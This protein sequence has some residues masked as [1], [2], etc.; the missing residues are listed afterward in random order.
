MSKLPTGIDLR[1]SGLYRVRVQGFPSKSFSRLPDAVEHRRTLTVAKQT[2]RMAQV[3]T[4]MIKLRELASEH[5][6]AEGAHLEQRTKNAYAAL[7]RANVLSHHVADMPLRMLTPK[8]IEDFR[9]DLLARGVG[10]QSVRKTLTIMQA[11]LGRGVRHGRITFNPAA[12]VKKPPARRQSVVRALS[13]VEVEKLRRQVKNGNAVLLSLLAYSGLRPEEARALTW[14]DIGQRTI[15]VDKACEP[16]GKVKATKSRRNRTVRL[17]APLGD[18]LKAFKRQAGNP[19]DS[20]LIFPRADGT[21]WTE[22]DY[23][24]WRKRTFRKAAADAK[25]A[26]ARPYDLRHS[27]ASL[28]LHEGVAPVQVAKWLGHSLAVLSETYAHVIE[29][30]D[31]DDRRSAVDMI[32]DA[33]QDNYRTDLRVLKGAKQSKSKAGKAAAG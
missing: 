33:R 22:T 31:P 24:N 16:D 2:G 29:D 30:L 10:P 28:W 23:R 19:A 9:D 27:A 18:D 11:I 21:A 32:R 7:W 20:A 13:P 25:V 14:G 3:G 6:A 8:V 17:L 15:N 5:M 26:I 12:A 4:D 1:P